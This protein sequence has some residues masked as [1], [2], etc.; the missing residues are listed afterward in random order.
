[1]PLGKP[2]ADTERSSFFR[3]T[4]T[5]LAWITLW[6]S[7][8]LGE[9]ITI[10]SHPVPLDEH[11]PE[12]TTVGALRYRGGLSLTSTHRD[13]GG[14]SGLRVSADGLT[15]H[16]VTDGGMF[17]TARLSYDSSGVLRGVTD[18]DLSR[19]PETG[20]TPRDGDAEA[21]SEDGSG[22]WIVAFE[23]RHRLM[24]MDDGKSPIGNIPL[25]SKASG[26]PPNSGI[27]ALTRLP[28]GQLLILAEHPAATG[29]HPGWL[30]GDGGCRELS[31]VPGVNFSPTDAT[32]L[33]SGDILVLERA[34]SLFG[35]W[36]ARIVHVAREQ[37]MAGAE[38]RGQSLALF[39]APLI[40]DNFEGLA[41]R[42]VPGNFR[43]YILSDDNFNF[44]QRTLLLTFDWPEL[45]P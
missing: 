22:G 19:L 27:E 9:P 25:P 41:A 1:M 39:R 3:L 8:A 33:P 24:R 43:I 29:K 17:L 28:D 40:V 5:L 35:G 15:L 42:S 16:A 32:T 2:V 7:P 34:F 13:F 26:L 20:R 21:L 6:V 37:V 11:A 44:L 38:I 18:A 10:V 36:G 12:S 45:Q 4:V 14:L 30:D 23:Q 31:Y